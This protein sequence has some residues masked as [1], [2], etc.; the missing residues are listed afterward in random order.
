MSR[1]GKLFGKLTPPVFKAD[2]G[3]REPQLA[4]ARKLPRKREPVLAASNWQEIKE[5][6]QAEVSGLVSKSIVESIY[7]A[8]PGI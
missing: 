3:R 6:L 2:E 7:C 1:I 8:Q 5:S 4:V